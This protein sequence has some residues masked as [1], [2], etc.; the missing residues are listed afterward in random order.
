M[1]RVEEE[2]NAMAASFGLDCQSCQ[3]EV[4]PLLTLKIFGR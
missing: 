2:K 1:D 3:N 4:D